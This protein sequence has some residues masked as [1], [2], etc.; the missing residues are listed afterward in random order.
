MLHAFAPDT[1]LSVF[2]AKARPGEKLGLFGVSQRTL[3]YVHDAPT[4]TVKIDRATEAVSLLTPVSPSQGGE[5]GAGPVPRD[6]VALTRKDLPAVN[7]LYR[8][9]HHSNL[10]VLGGPKT[11]TSDDA[12]LL[13]TSMLLPGETNA[14]PI[15]GFLFEAPPTMQRPLDVDFDGKLSAKGWEIVEVDGTKVSHVAPRS[16]FHLKIALGVDQAPGAGYCTFIHLEHSPTR[17]TAEHKDFA[18]YPMGLWQHGD[19]VMDDF[20]IKL[21][22]QFGPGRYTLYYGVGL[23]PC[24]DDKRLAVKRGPSDGHDRVRMGDVEVR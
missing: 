5:A 23:L 7:A 6:F 24:E 4:S 1:A 19:V 11:V 18:T 21:S 17:M 2:A 8:Q 20:E 15:E 9:E 3:A 10:P 22:P 13:A 12:V 16:T 14:N